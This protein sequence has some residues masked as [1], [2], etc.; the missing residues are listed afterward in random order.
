VARTFDEADLLE[1]VDNDLA[2]LAETAEMLS[3]DGALLLEQIRAGLH[4]ND[5]AAVGR[6]AHAL[7]G[8]ISNFCAPATQA[9]ALDLERHGKAGD[10]SRAA[11]LLA[12]LEQSLAELTSE[13]AA[14]IKA[15]S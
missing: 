8:M 15:R 13:L 9:L 12:S 4:A 7:K 6:S 5:P 14:F 11:P 2:F 10:I 1:R 3:S